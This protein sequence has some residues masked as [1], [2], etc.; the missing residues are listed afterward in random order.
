MSALAKVLIVGGIWLVYTFLFFGMTAN[1]QGG[2][3]PE[4][5]A[6]EKPEGEAAR[7]VNTYPVAFRWSVDT[8]FTTDR[9]A[10]RK[11]ALLSKMTDNNILEITGL[12]YEAEDNPT[13]AATLGFA[14]AERIKA[15]LEGDVPADRIRLRAR[16]EDEKEGVRTGYFPGVDFEWIAV[17]EVV[18]KSV[19]EL[20]DRIIIRFP[21]GSA[22]KEYSPEVD[23]YLEK[24]AARIQET[25]ETVSLTGHTDNTGSP[26][27][28]L[29]LGRQRA[30]GIRDL[31]V[32]MG[33]SP[34]Q[35][36]TTTKGESQPVDSNETEEGRHNNRRVEVRL[37]IQ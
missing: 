9:W 3:A 7:A 35:I 17:E 29:D 20:E 12:Y 33:V 19:E 24:L 31:L 11:K 26:E 27:F 8:A 6:V 22:Q 16:V 23:E 1:I 32:D 18:E 36:S 10:N 4:E 14:R 37:N 21:Y 2:D 30:E 15:L 25:K 28:N 13:E 34:Q 5:E